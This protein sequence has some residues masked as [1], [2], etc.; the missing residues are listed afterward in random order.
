MPYGWY[1]SRALPNEFRTVN[2]KVCPINA[3]TPA[4]FWMVGMV[5]SSDLAMVN[6]ASRW[7][8]NLSPLEGEV[9]AMAYFVSKFLNTQSSQLPIYT[10]NGGIAF[11]SSKARKYMPASFIMVYVLTLR[12]QLSLLPAKHLT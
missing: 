11:T 2:Y 10:W 12:D 7:G 8:I 5:T 6:G 9:D 3:V 4:K 1:V